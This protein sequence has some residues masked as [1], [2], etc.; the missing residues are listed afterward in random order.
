MQKN[1]KKGRDLV[2]FTRRSYEDSV[3]YV[4]NYDFLIITLEKRKVRDGADS[5]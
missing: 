1:K 5:I 3:L 2:C 4:V